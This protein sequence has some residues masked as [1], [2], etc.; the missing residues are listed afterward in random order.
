MALDLNHAVEYGTAD[1]AS[2]NFISAY[3]ALTLRVGN[4]IIIATAVVLKKKD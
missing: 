3:S 1:L 2:T 4:L